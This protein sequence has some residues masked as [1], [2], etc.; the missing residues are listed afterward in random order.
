MIAFDAFHL[1]DKLLTQPLQIIVGAKGG[2]FN[3]FQ[4]GKDLYN[5]SASKEKDLLFEE[6]FS[7][8]VHIKNVE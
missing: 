1:I 7:I 8:F 3:S 6:K 5:R 4:D 2:A